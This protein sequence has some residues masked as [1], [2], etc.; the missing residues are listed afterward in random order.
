MN[1]IFSAGIIKSD[2][3]GNR[4]KKPYVT[5]VLNTLNENNETLTGQIKG[6]LNQEGVKVQLIVSTVEDDPSILFVKKEF[7]RITL[8]IMPR[9]LHPISRGLRLP[10][11][12]FMQLNNA[13]KLMKGDWFTF[14]AA[15]DKVYPKKLQIETTCCLREKKEV[16]Y[17]AFD[18]IEKGKKNRYQSFFEYDFTRHLEGN[19][20]SDCALV[21]KR[22]IKKYTPFRTELNNYAFWDLWL[23]IHEGEGNVFCYN[24][25]ETWG[26]VQSSSSMHI[27]RRN[28]PLELRRSEADKK[29]MLTFHF[30]LNKA[31]MKVLNICKNDYANFAWDNTKALRS[32]GIES[33]CMKTVVHP[34]DYQEHGDVVKLQDIIRELPKYD[35]IQ[36]FFNIDLYRL[37]APHLRRKKLVVYYASS[38]FRDNKNRYLAT[39]NPVVHK[40]VIALGEFA[41][42]GARNEVYVVG[43][44]DTDKLCPNGHKTMKPFK[45]AHYPSN[46]LVKGS[47]TINRIA[48]NIKNIRYKFSDKKVGFDEQ[49]ERMKDCDIYIELF[50]PTLNGNKY[51][52]FGITALE[53]AALGKIV[54]TQNLSR[55]IYEMNYGCCPLM[56]VETEEELKDKLE[57][58]AGMTTAEIRFLQEKTREWVVKNHSYL[59]TGRRIKE[60]V[61]CL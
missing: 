27:L 48:K 42:Y 3:G 5:V 22:L 36:F 28:N 12:S 45:V 18:Y 37:L 24:P 4:L 43:A 46:T 38:D 49:I 32:A 34:F 2:S 23:R 29:R 9:E 57:M 39:F 47:E 54:I 55:D 7:P 20:V 60:K 10:L 16:C 52:S 59:A 15:N 56:L 1:I 35:F 8:A 33:R 31:K 19:F 26:Y 14:A 53:A 25:V 58:L 17:S 61:L 40:S 21:S 11:G 51:G 50:N 13:L 41:G 30:N 6:F 44:V